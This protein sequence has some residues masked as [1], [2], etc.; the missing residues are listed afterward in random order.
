MMEWRLS[1]NRFDGSCART[2]PSPIPRL[3]CFS[4][5]YTSRRSFVSITSS[6]SSSSWSRIQWMSINTLQPCPRHRL[7]MGFMICPSIEFCHSVD[8]VTAS[9]VSPG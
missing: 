3:G 7:C 9:G 8:S 1:R 4:P 5:S 6:D 2:G